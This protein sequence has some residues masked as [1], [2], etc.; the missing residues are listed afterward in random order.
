MVPELPGLTQ[1]RLA[2]RSK[3]RAVDGTPE[4]ERMSRKNGTSLIPYFY[5]WLIFMVNVGKYTIHGSY[6]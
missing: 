2:H 4:N 1:L 3:N 5:I 6:G